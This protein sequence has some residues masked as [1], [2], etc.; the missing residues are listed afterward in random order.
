M[1]SRSLDKQPKRTL[2]WFSPEEKFPRNCIPLL[3]KAVC[4]ILIEKCPLH[5]LFGCD[6]HIEPSPNT[7]RETKGR[8]GRTRHFQIF[9][10]NSMSKVVIYRINRVFSPLPFLFLSTTWRNDIL[11]SVVHAHAYTHTHT[12]AEYKQVQKALESH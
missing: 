12:N 8:R 2:P 4:S 9:F 6:A 10:L 7:E 11:K 3:G 1:V 5:P